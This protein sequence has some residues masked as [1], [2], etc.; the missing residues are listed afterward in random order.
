MSERDSHT[1]DSVKSLESRMGSG[2][3]SN[4]GAPL[5][6]TARPVFNPGD[7]GGVLDSFK[8]RV[9]LTAG[10]TGGDT[11]PSVGAVERLLFRSKLL[12]LL[13]AYSRETCI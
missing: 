10:D 7:D 5:E 8:A 12:S 11:L 3:W 9:V 6:P 1:T 4:S 2:D 13:C